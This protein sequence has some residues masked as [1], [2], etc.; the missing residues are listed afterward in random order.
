MMTVEPPPEQPRAIESQRF[1]DRIS[2]E[3]MLEWQEKYPL[4]DEEIHPMIPALQC[5]AKMTNDDAR[6]F[7][8]WIRARVAERRIA[9]AEAA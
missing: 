9:K 4:V 3:Q 6:A 5:A 8:R 2:I 1:Q 7:P